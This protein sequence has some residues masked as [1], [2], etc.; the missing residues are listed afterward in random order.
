M[1]DLPSAVT[2]AKEKQSKLLKE[3][4]P[5][6]AK[7]ITDQATAQFRSASSLVDSPVLA[8]S[9]TNESE[10]TG[11][12]KSSQKVSSLT[13]KKN[14]KSP[15]V[16]VLLSPTSARKRFDDQDFVFGT[17]SQLEKTGDDEATHDNQ[18]DDY[19][20]PSAST[21]VARRDFLQSLAKERKGSSIPRGYNAENDKINIRHD[22][23]NVVTNRMREQPHQDAR[24][25]RSQLVKV[26][27]A[28]SG[29]WNAAARDLD[30]ELMSVEV[31][32]MTGSDNGHL[33]SES[34][35]WNEERTVRE[36]PG[37]RNVTTGS[38]ATGRPVAQNGP[39]EPCNSARRDPLLVEEAFHKN[40]QVQAIE[41]LKDTSNA[42]IL[43]PLERSPDNVTAS[44]SVGTKTERS[45]ASEQ[46]KPAPVMPDFQSYPTSKLKAEVAKFGFKDMKTRDM[47]V[48][49]LEMCWEAKNKAATARSTPQQPEANAG[50]VEN[51]TKLPEQGSNKK[52]TALVLQEAISTE[53]VAKGKRY[54][55]RR[56][57]SPRHKSPKRKTASKSKKSSSKVPSHDDDDEPGG[58][59]PSAKAVHY[60]ISEVVHESGKTESESSFYHAILM[61]DP[62]ILEDMTLWLNTKDKL[63]DLCIDEEVVKAWCEAN[64][65]CCVR[66]ETIAGKERKR[67]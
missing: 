45:T 49:C 40:S 60:R 46:T 28:A 13:K 52:E 37:D 14:K 16:I 47:M 7:T 26:R 30:G 51:T 57:K 58:I 21:S 36:L 3:K 6:K 15:E 29:L 56:S 19:V 35:G 8:Y 27:K 50:P 59:E 67:F 43:R 33:E 23:V 62:I 2:V 54:A 10:G 38:N 12:K 9:A 24:Q 20:L 41:S 25:G 18:N 53:I 44:T 55:R 64:G 48:S 11:P 61:Y 42:I 5:K 32:D 22:G 65:V 1:I 66:K 63:R 17:C 39:L 31:V 4:Q 34:T